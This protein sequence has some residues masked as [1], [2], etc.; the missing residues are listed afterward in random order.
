MKKT[1]GQLL[2]RNERGHGDLTAEESSAIARLIEFFAIVEEELP[3]ALSVPA[4]ENHDSEVSPDG[5][6]G[7]GAICATYAAWIA[8]EPQAKVG[9]HDGVQQLAEVARA[10][11]LTL[12][13]LGSIRD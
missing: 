1:L 12:D 7:L 4:W 3:K 5:Y 10:L 6:N 2:G 11:P 8:E 9:E 13:F